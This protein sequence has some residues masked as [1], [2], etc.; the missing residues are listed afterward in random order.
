MRAIIYIIM[1]VVFTALFSFMNLERKESR[2]VNK[3]P[4]EVYAALET[5]LSKPSQELADGVF[6][7]EPHFNVTFTGIKDTELHLRIT[8]SDGQLFKADFN[9]TTPDEG[10]ST[11]VV[12]YF[13]PR[14]VVQQLNKEGYSGDLNDMANTLFYHQIEQVIDPAKYGEPAVSEFYV[15]DFRNSLRA[16]GYLSPR[17]R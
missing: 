3:P 6:A 15:S 17:R 8:R 2:E 4:S 16:K 1:V 9:L 10:K 7:Q 11:K 13:D 5:Y 14:G 12:M